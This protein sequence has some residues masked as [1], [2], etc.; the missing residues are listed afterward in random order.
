MTAEEL[1][2]EAPALQGDPA[3][4]TDQDAVQGLVEDG[5]HIGGPV[6]EGR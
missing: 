5:I 2:G 4:E 6:D 3:R 1:G